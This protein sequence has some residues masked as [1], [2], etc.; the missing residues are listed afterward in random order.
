MA[1]PLLALDVDGPLA[2]MGEPD[3]S[4]V[5]EGCVDEIPLV[6]SR[7]LPQRLSRLA[8]VFQIV[9]SSTKL[10]QIK[11]S[12]ARERAPLPRCC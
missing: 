12:V 2:L 5:F 10:A 8:A 4:E 1:R 6:F 7:R 11:R 3:P 9:W